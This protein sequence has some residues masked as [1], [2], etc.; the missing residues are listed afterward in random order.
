MNKMEA[1]EINVGSLMNNE[2]LPQLVKSL[3]MVVNLS[4]I[5]SNSMSMLYG[6]TQ[7]ENKN[8]NFQQ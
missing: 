8:S 4:L 7:S 5:E 6:A 3:S 1:N 2:N